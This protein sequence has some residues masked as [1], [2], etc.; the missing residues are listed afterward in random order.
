[1]DKGCTVPVQASQHH[2]IIVQPM[3]ASNY[4]V[5]SPKQHGS[6]F[7][8]LACTGGA[9]EGACGRWPDPLAVKC[10]MSSADD[11]VHFGSCTEATAHF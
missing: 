8:T 6:L 3:H 9:P 7:Q 2:G 10:E 4:I 11:F 1:M 5:E